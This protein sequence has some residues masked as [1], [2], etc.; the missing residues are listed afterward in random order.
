MT[1]GKQITQVLAGS[2]VLS[3]GSPS[4]NLRDYHKANEVKS[5]L[6]CHGAKRLSEVKRVLHPYRVTVALAWDM[7][8]ICI[9]NNST[10]LAIEL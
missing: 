2:H 8:K 9:R 1:I 4:D 6:R 3:N 5:A 10:G 7:S